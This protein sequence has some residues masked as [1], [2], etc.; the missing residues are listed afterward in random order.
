MPATSDNPTFGLIR[1]RKEAIPPETL[2]LF[3]Q[4][5]QIPFESAVSQFVDLVG[6]H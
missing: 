3:L 1:A 4:D 2:R 6:F 5:N